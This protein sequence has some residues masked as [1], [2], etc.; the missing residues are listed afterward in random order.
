MPKVKRPRVVRSSI[1][2]QANR[3]CD[4]NALRDVAKYIVVVLIAS[5]AALAVTVTPAHAVVIP[6]EVFVHVSNARA[7]GHPDLEVGGGTVDKRE[8]SVLFG[9]PKAIEI[10]VGGVVRDIG[11]RLPAGLVGNPQAVP[12]C[13]PTLFYANECPADTQVGTFTATVCVLKV[14]NLEVPTIATYK[15]N[16]FLLTG[17]PTV[18]ARLGFTVLLPGGFAATAAA[19][20]V[21]TVHPSENDRITLTI[22]EVTKL[23][24]N[25]F[26]AGSF[27]TWGVP[28][29]HQR[30]GGHVN[31]NFLEPSTFSEHIPPD[32]PSQRKPFLQYPTD[33]TVTPSLTTFV[34]TYEEPTV[35]AENTLEVPQPTNCQSV[36]FA[37]TVSV[38]PRPAEHPTEDA[39]RA[40]SPT[41]M[42]VELS[43]PQNESP[44]GVGTSALKEAVLKF[45]PGVVVS[46]S[47]AANGLQACTDEE[48]AVSSDG[49]SRC[50]HASLI[51]EDEIETPLLPGPLKGS[52]YLGQ[53][54]SS[55]PES[56]KLFRIFQEFKGFGIDL[57]LEGAASVNATTGQIEIKAGVPAAGE[58]NLPELPFTHFRVHTRGGPDA[59][60]V[61]QSGCGPS[62]TTSALTGYSKPGEPATPSGTYTTSYD[63]H[64]APCPAALPFAPS[65]SLSGGSTQAGAFSPLTVVFSRQD[66]EQPLGRFTTTLPPGLLGY[67]S[68]VPLCEPAEAATGTCP[69]AS[70]VGVVSATVGPGSAPLTLPGS[71]YLA[72]GTGGY[73]FELSVVVP[74]I[75][76]PFD[77]GNVTE[78]IGLE[79]HSDGTL[80]AVS[81]QLPSIKDGVP[82]DIRTITATFDRPGFTFNPTNCGHLSMTGQITS[83]SGTVAPVS[84]PFQVSGC[85]SLPFKPSFRAVTASNPSKSNGESLQVRVEQPAGQAH[86]AKVRVELPKQMPSRLTTLQKACTEAQ[87]NANP[88]GCPP[89]SVV[90][91]AT[92]YTPLLDNP[93]RGPAIFVSHGGAKFPELIIILQ[94]E[95]LTI[96]LNG[97]TFID[98]KTGVTS[99]TFNAVPDVPFSAF[100]LKLP[101]GPYSALGFNGTPCTSTL[102]MP[103]TITSQ[104]GTVIKQAT[105]IA[106]TGCPKAKKA[107]KARKA[108]RAR[109][110]RRAR[111]A[112]YTRE[113]RRQ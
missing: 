77:L 17:G 90:G 42:T 25:A 11:G 74:A 81:G 36:P 41:G 93:L 4:G 15:G 72:R 5:L 113:G 37:P 55:D 70:R 101:E 10:P 53:P 51:G 88:A 50:P 71:I 100:D 83:L 22:H 108:R 99:S 48:F 87:F 86:I 49:A 61:N 2:R 7:G 29:E 45:P 38:G 110:A 26:L 58:P 102:V 91:T 73:P 109:R 92:V 107:K 62:T 47:A 89:G 65:A 35:F 18:P 68:A 13:S 82:T 40:G 78:V 80:T 67:V 64:G 79:V 66:G 52:A 32:P 27:T 76:G 112:A 21:V 44:S 6:K 43:L 69:A 84:A 106:V 96:Y 20:A 56:G 57:K 46:P 103:T 12:Q 16:I 14:A 105:K 28:G 63:G 31:G 98:G 34:N 3:P 111:H 104:A 33:C 94:G 60:L 75:A 59:V 24:E 9:E 1:G 39:T 85:G 23:G 19:M 95:G 30:S 8:F 54:L 97:E